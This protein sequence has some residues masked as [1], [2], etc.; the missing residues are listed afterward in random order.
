[1]L[2]FYKKDLIPAHITLLHSFCLMI[3]SVVQP[4]II[5]MSGDGS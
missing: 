3:I 2:Y 5:L 1:M 4:L